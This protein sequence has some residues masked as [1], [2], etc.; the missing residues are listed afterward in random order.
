M[1]LNNN[2]W[3]SFSC[4]PFEMTEGYPDGMGRQTSLTPVISQDMVTA[5]EHH[6][7]HPE[8]SRYIEICQDMVPKHLKIYIPDSL[9]SSDTK[10]KLPLLGSIFITAVSSV[11]PPMFMLPRERVFAPLIF[12]CILSEWFLSSSMVFRVCSTTCMG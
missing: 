10:N 8:Y 12:M 11:Q 7:I 3:L 5:F 2:Q 1:S 9:W 4:L 6:G